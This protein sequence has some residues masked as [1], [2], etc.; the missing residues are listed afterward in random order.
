M[1]NLCVI[2]T[3]RRHNT[4]YWLRQSNMAALK[5]VM[6]HVVKNLP[7]P[8]GAAILEQAIP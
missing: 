6:L 8:A 4:A 7:D 5:C 3:N 2:L 1:N